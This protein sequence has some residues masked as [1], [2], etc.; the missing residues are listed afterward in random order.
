L[1]E[2]IIHKDVPLLQAV[3]ED[4]FSAVLVK[5]RSNYVSLRRLTNASKKQG[6]LFADPDMLQALHAVED[7]AYQ[8]DDGSQAS[9]PP[10]GRGFPGVWDKVRSDSGNCMG[11]RCPMYDRCFYQQSRR[12]MENAD[13]LVVNHALFFSDLALRVEGHGFLP[14]YDHVILDEAHMVEDVASDHFGVSCSESH[15][16]FLLAAM[17]QPRTGKGFLATLDKKLDAS[18]VDRVIGRVHDASQ[19][20]YALFDDLERYQQTQGRTNGRINDAN[21]V[22][23]GLSGKLTDLSLSLKLLRD[24]VKDE[25]DRFEINGY[26]ARCEGIAAA[27]TALLE[28]SLDDCVYW[29]E[30]VP[31]NQHRSIRRISISGSP[32]DVG[33]LLAERLFEAKNKQ[34]EP[35]G[36]VLTSATLATGQSNGKA[37]NPFAHIQKRL[38][39]TDAATLQLGSPFDYATQAQLIVEPRLPDP[40][41]RDFAEKLVPRILH[42]VERTRGGAF[43]LFTSYT[44]LRQAVAALKGPLADRGFAVLVQGEGEQRTTLLELFRNDP[45][46]VL[47]GT[48]SF[49]QGVDVQGDALRNVIITRLPF[50]SPDRPLLEARMERIKARG[51]NPF[52]EYS[53]PDAILKFKQGF[54]RLIRSTRDEG[55]VVVLDSRIVNKS[56]GRRFIAALPDVPVRTVDEPIEYFDDITTS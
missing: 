10:M 14:P 46:S 35:I 56:Y 52:G 17:Y 11:R 25:A 5:G 1:Q 48:D 36:V 41:S 3:I 27:V 49:W 31:A 53:L 45:H 2:Q 50:A 43:V 12:R 19:A 47:F 29:M 33:P 37:T 13:L 44:L 42:H 24:Q 21:I 40:N 6:H 16:R 26:T 20:A 7:W 9:M 38:G 15:V 8:T 32:I 51:G 4:E 54:G 23:N 22:P 39:C 18:L 30:F 34:G 28:Q 55:C